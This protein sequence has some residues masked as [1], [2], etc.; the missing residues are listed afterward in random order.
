MIDNHKKERIYDRAMVEEYKYKCYSTLRSMVCPGRTRLSEQDWILYKSYCDNME[1]LA[2]HGIY[3]EI[4][5]VAYAISIA[6]L[7]KTR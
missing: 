2:L 6:R 3:S 5:P 7:I 1:L 4:D